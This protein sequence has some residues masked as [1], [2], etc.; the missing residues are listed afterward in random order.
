MKTNAEDSEVE[1]MH[2]HLEDHQNLEA[3][4]TQLLKNLV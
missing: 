3:N 4:T 1:N 2:D